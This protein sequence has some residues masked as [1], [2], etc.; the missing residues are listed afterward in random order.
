MPDFFLPKKE[1]SGYSADIFRS[2]VDGQFYR[3]FD[4]QRRNGLAE[5][6]AVHQ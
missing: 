2:S 1:K 4:G 3:H 6:L 5:G